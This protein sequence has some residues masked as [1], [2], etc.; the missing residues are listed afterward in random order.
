[1]VQHTTLSIIKTLR[2]CVSASQRLGFLLADYIVINKMFGKLK[3]V[4]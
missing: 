4:P 3:K 2:H 1:M